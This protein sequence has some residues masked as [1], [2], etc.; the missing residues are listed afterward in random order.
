MTLITKIINAMKFKQLP[1]VVTTAQVKQ[2]VVAK[3]IVND[4]GDLYT[5][6][7]IEAILSNSDVKNNPTTNTNKKMLASRLNESGKKEYWF[8]R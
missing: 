5:K 2:W 4:D 6:A 3:S 7:S 1:R 8:R